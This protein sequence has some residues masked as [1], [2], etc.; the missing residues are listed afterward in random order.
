MY[1]VYTPCMY[2]VYIYLSS[3]RGV[4]NTFLMQLSYMYVV[5]GPEGTESM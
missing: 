4:T 5:P 2:N 3:K 1:E